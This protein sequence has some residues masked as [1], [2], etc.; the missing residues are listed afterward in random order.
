MDNVIVDRRSHHL[1]ELTDTDLCVVLA[2][3][4][5]GQSTTI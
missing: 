1:K 5:E 4:R 2:E 3:V